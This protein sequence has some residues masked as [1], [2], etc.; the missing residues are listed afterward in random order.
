MRLGI[1]TPR[2]WSATGANS[3]AL[4]AERDQALA[5]KQALAAKSAAELD[6]AAREHSLA[7]AALDKDRD[8][9]RAEKESIAAE[10]EK[11]KADHAAALQ[12]AAGAARRGACGE[13]GSGGEPRRGIRRRGKSADATQEEPSGDAGEGSF[14]DPP[15]R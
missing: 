8:A 9:L 15:E 1:S 14:R 10:M 5:D 6:A 7:V 11:A 12:R 2:R 4:T 13:D 3:R